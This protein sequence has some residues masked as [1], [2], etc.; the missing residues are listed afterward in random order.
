VVAQLRVLRN[1]SSRDVLRGR[2]GQ[3]KW[4]STLKSNI[5]YTTRAILC[6]VATMAWAGSS[7][8]LMRRWKAPKA[9]SA[10]IAEAAARPLW[11]A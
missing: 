8:D 5:R 10:R 6:A 11:E 2:K 9:Q 1:S 7:R 4:Y 3:G